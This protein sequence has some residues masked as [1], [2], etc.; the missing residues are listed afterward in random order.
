MALWLF[1]FLVLAAALSKYP[2]P[3]QT[4]AVISRDYADNRNDGSSSRKQCAA[5]AVQ[6]QIMAAQ[7]ALRLQTLP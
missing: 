2:G 7:D 3:G 4:D 1:T 5:F 6:I